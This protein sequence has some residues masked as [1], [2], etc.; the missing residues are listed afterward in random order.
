M[1]KQTALAAA[2]KK[3]AP[4][5]VN[6]EGLN[7]IREMYPMHSAAEIARRLN[8][9]KDTVNARAREMGVRHAPA[10][11]D[12]HPCARRRDPETLRRERLEKE[13][14]K[15]ERAAPCY[16]GGNAAKLRRLWFTHTIAEC[17]QTLR[18]DGRPWGF[19][20][21]LYRARKYGLPFDD[22]KKAECDERAKYL[23]GVFRGA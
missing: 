19:S 13:R 14:R 5:K 16:G 1:T 17:G 6:A 11:Y 21:T 7:L 3:G 18:E 12:A 23:A 10:F 20:L 8:V 15:A 4:R 22:A 2:P 9:S